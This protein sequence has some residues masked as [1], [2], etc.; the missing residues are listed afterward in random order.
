M[1]LHGIKNKVN[2]KADY[3]KISEANY[4]IPFFLHFNTPKIKWAAEFLNF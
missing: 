1:F 4:L 3:M 2:S